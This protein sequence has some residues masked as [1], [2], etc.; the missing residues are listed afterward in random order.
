[1]G[2]RLRRGVLSSVLFFVISSLYCSRCLLCHGK[3]RCWCGANARAGKRSWR[4][5]FSVRPVEDDSQPCRRF[6][7]SGRGPAN[8]PKDRERR[9]YATAPLY[10]GRS[11]RNGTQYQ[12][13]WPVCGLCLHELIDLFC[14]SSK[15]PYILLSVCFSYVKYIYLFYY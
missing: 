15:F 4:G 11:I 7:H 10:C 5:S 13:R 9:A 2:S 8:H 14:R 3:H 1:M 6:A 12:S